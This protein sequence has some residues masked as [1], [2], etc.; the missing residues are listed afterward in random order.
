M[1]ASGIQRQGTYDLQTVEIPDWRPWR[2]M[3]V[4][5]FLIRWYA[6][7][8]S[9]VVKPHMAKSKRTDSDR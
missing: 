7:W 3:V 5:L 8:I 9:L 2:V 4:T 6:G 1:L